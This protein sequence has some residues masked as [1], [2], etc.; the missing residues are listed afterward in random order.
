MKTSRFFLPRAPTATRAFA[1]MKLFLLVIFTAGLVAEIL[2]TYFTITAFKERVAGARTRSE[3]QIF[4]THWQFFLFT[5]IWLSLAQFLAIWAAA[6]EY[7]P[8]LVAYAF[9]TVAAMV[10]QLMGAF[11][12]DDERVL[13]AQI[14]GAIPEAV[15]VLLALIFA[16]M[17]K[18]SDAHLANLPLYRRTMAES[19]KTSNCE[20][21]DG[22]GTRREPY[23][24]GLDGDNNNLDARDL[25]SHFGHH[26]TAGLDEEMFRRKE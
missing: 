10:F 20:I 23:S 2:Y 13:W 4:K 16:R 19:R 22:D 12:A 7:V 15:L 26:L 3:I 18:S 11:A 8:V 24:I 6:L 21:L 9:A 1:A 14:Y 5:G 25:E 17:V